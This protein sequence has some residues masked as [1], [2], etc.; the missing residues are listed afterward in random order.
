M[1]EGPITDAKLALAGERLL[2]AFCGPLH[3][4]F[5]EHIDQAKRCVTA[6]NCSAANRICAADT[7]RS[8]DLHRCF[9]VFRYVPV[10]KRECATWIEE[11][12]NEAIPKTRASAWACARPEVSSAPSPGPT[13]D[14]VDRI[15]R[16]ERL[17][18][19]SDRS[20]VSLLGRAWFCRDDRPRSLS[21]RMSPGGKRRPR[22]VFGDW[23]RQQDKPL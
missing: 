17:M 8:I 22:P 16:V 23:L 20:S 1:D 12:A 2:E 7:R 11:S 5:T 9:D 13:R 18:F 21:S 19:R 10:L 14:H 4:R 3:D 6:G 15:T